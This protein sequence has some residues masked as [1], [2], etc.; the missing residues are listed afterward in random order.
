M[1]LRRFLL[2]LAQNLRFVRNV[3]KKAFLAAIDLR[4]ALAHHRRF[5]ARTG[6]QRALVLNCLKGGFFS[7]SRTCLVIV[8]GT[9][10]KMLEASSGDEPEEDQLW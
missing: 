5:S 7:G 6:A 2:H 3:K 10:M 8:Q 9:I 4:R 1:L